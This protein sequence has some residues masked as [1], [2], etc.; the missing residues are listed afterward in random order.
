[1]NT[2]AG[3]VTT[4]KS[5]NRPPAIPYDGYVEDLRRVRAQEEQEAKE[6]APLPPVQPRTYSDSDEEK[7]LL[8][9]VVRVPIML[10]FAVIIVVFGVPMAILRLGS[11]ITTRT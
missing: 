4:R 6:A 5:Y 3:D 9:W 8:E 10:A 11:R 2:I 7:S 1:M